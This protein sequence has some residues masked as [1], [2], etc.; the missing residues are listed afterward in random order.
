MPGIDSIKQNVGN[1]A[2]N[3]ENTGLDESTID[4]EKLAAALYEKLRSEIEIENER[5]GRSWEH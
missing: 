3:Q 2:S 5:L 1:I 4:L